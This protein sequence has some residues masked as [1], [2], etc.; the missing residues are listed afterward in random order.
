[1]FQTQAREKNE[2]GNLRPK[3]IAHSFQHRDE[4][5]LNDIGSWDISSIAWDMLW[6]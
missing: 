6:Y 4:P 3:F 5:G 2:N 1:M